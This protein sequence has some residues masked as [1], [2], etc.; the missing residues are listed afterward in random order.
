MGGSRAVV[1]RLSVVSW[2][3]ER[4]V[5]NCGREGVRSVGVTW[6][7]CWEAVV[8]AKLGEG[9]AWGLGFGV[10]TAGCESLGEGISSLTVGEEL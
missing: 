8:A 1:I 10:S 3:E 6:G 9:L 5:S 7:E 4:G 2:G